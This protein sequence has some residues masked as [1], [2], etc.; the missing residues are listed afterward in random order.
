MP[1]AVRSNDTEKFDLKTLPGAFV[2]LRRM[3]YGQILERRALMKLTFTSQGTGKSAE[4]EIAMANRAINLFEFRHCVV[5][6]NL[7]RVEGQ[8]LNLNNAQDVDSLD[9]KVGQEVEKLIESLN[10]LEDEDSGDEDP[11]NSSGE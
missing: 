3:S 9:P 4:G 1:V 8:L 10:N 11:G 7:E 2:V 6:H 5:E